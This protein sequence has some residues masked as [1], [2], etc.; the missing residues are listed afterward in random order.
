MTVMRRCAL[1][2]ISMT[3][4]AG[5]GPDGRPAPKWVDRQVPA[6]VQPAPPPPVRNV[7]IDP[8]LLTAAKAELNAGLGSKMPEDRMHAIEAMQQT[9]GVAAKDVYLK[10]L[11]SEMPEV[12]YASAM[13]IGHLQIAE[14]KE[15]LT[16]MVNDGDG[17]VYIAVRFALHRLGDTRFS[18]DL[19]TTA[20]DPLIW[21]H[22]AMTAMLLGYLNEPTAVRILKPMQKDDQAAVRIQVAEALWRM[23]EMDG[24]TKPGGGR[25]EQVRRRPIDRADGADGAEGRAGAG[26]YSPVADGGAL[27]SSPDG[28]PGDGDIGLGCGVWNRGGRG[29]EQGCSSAGAGGAGAGGDRAERRPAAIGGAAEGRGFG[30]RSA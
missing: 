30:G 24:L 27:G 13:A 4:L 1:C 6:P 19:Q 10:G 12:R 17:N 25:P 22:R 14:A 23:G 11:S 29:G 5:C 26:A 7:S 8:S 21:Q 16:Q 20:R 28:R 2:L 3:A 9:I 18:K 15:P